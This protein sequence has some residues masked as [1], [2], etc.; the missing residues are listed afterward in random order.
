MQEEKINDKKK[1][2]ENEFKFISFEIIK[3]CQQ[4]IKKIIKRK[5]YFSE[6]KGDWICFNCDN[7]ILVLE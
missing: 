5:K 2:N 3:F 6:R 1:I 7:L 4:R